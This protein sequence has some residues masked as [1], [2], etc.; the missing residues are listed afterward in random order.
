M[1]TKK[2]AAKQVTKTATAV[3]ASPANGHAKPA[4]IVVPDAPPGFVRVPIDPVWWSEETELHGAIFDVEMT[5]GPRGDAVQSVVVVTSSRCRGVDNWG[6]ALDTEPS[7]V[8]RLYQPALLRLGR[9]AADPE[10]VHNVVIQCVTDRGRKRY[11]VAVS[12]EP[13]PRASLTPR[14]PR[15]L[16]S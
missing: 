10:S 3:R 14:A 9:M 16:A 8:L 1:T 6:Q 12:Q 4:Q 7:D 2:I 15:A 5:E 13:V 11:L